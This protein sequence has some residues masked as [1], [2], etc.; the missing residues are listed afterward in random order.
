MAVRA[1]ET[2]RPTLALCVSLAL[3]VKSLVL[4]SLLVYSTL[5]CVTE[6]SEDREKREATTSSSKK[7][8]SHIAE[9]ADR[10]KIHTYTAQKL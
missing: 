10:G 8:R 5:L 2:D 4:F 9:A 6:G 7:K 3:T 1:G